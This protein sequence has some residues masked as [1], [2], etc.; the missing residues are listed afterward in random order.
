LRRAIP[1]SPIKPETNSQAAAGIGTAANL[2]PPVAPGLAAAHPVPD[3]LHGK[4]RAA[5]TFPVAFA[6]SAFAAEAHV[7][8]VSVNKKVVVLDAWVHPSKLSIV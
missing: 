8:P 4:I 6:I 2:V 1:I 7:P 3:G 5:A